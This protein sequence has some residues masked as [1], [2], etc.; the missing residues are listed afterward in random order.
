[1]TATDP[2]DLGALEARRL[3]ARKALSPIE[4]AEASIKR[5]ERLDHAVNALI[6]RDFDGLITGAKKAE[7]AVMSGEPL[8]ALHGLSFGVK[9][10]IDVIGLPT[11]FG[12]EAFRDNIAPKDDAIVAAMRKAGAIP[13]GKTNNPEWSAGGNTRNRVYGVTANPYDLSRT[14]AGSSGGSAGR[15]GLRL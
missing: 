11:T 10:M 12:S 6:V 8:G 1:M 7:D 14:C 5:V 9:D 15:V 13:M 2:A 3:I 4:L